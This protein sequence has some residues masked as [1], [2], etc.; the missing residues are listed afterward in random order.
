M[1]SA[2]EERVV[3]KGVVVRNAK[4]QPVR[5]EDAEFEVLLESPPLVGLVGL[6]PNFTGGLSLRDYTE[7]ICS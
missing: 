2:L 5:V 3:V 1:T 6:D 4:G 7:R